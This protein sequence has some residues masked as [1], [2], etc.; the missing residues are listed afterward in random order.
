MSTEGA[1][2]DD[3]RLEL[4]SKIENAAWRTA[5]DALAMPPAFGHT[6]TITAA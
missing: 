4:I 3:P 5:T 1:D 6:A 2:A